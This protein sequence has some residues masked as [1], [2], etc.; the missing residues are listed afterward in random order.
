MNFYPQTSRN[1]ETEDMH[2]DNS[3]TA[4]LLNIYILLNL[5]VAEN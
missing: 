2:K 3:L 5:Y 1:G 4:V